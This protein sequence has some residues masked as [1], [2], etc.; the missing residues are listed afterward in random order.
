MTTLHLG[1]AVARRYR[2]RTE[3]EVEA[4]GRAELLAVLG[5]DESPWDDDA[6][7]AEAAGVPVE[8]GVYDDAPRVLD[9]AVSGHSNLFQ[10]VDEVC[11]IWRIHS[12]DVAPAWIVG[13]DETLVA[14]V[15][16]ALEHELVLVPALDED[17]DPYEVEQ[18]DADGNPT[19]EWVQAMVTE[20]RRVA[21]IEVGLPVDVEETHYT[22]AGAPGLDNGL[23]WGGLTKAP[24]PTPGR[25]KKTQGGGGLPPRSMGTFG[26]LTFLT[27]VL[28]ATLGTRLFLHT[29]AG[30]DHASRVQFDTASNGTGSYAAANWIA[31]TENSTAPST[32][33]TT[34]TGELSTEG[35]ARA[36]ATYA[37]TNGTTTV[38]L[39]KTFTMTSGTSRTPAK[40]GM[41]TASS[42]GTLKYETLV[43]SPP[44]L[45][46]NDSVAV[47]WTVSLS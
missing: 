11:R 12:A 30:I 22:C 39:T 33:S 46:P 21:D 32:A 4:M 23:E 25:R 13:D 9:I 47:T 16:D 31:L 35:F 24:K 20:R 41:F 15:K 34:L 3:A 17:G 7:R 28:A 27:L 2:N 43:P 29:S 10:A 26:F 6:L 19:G 5:V 42:G 37:H 38:S 8:I 44:T 1:M 36:Q 14:A 40:G 18:T 45:V